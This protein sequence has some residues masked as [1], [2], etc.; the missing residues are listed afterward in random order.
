VSGKIFNP[1]SSL[2]DRSNDPY[3]VSR[4]VSKPFLHWNDVS[5]RS[6]VSFFIYLVSRPEHHIS[7]CLFTKTRVLHTIDPSK[8]RGFRMIEMQ[9][10][11]K[12]I[13][14]INLNQI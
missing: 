5:L 14:E 7:Q 13:C 4:G 8:M 1:G 11:L 3:Y 6:G 12:K 10:Y 9:R 2:I